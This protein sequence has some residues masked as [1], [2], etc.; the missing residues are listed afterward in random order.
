MGSIMAYGYG[1]GHGLELWLRAIAL[2][3][4]YGLGKWVQLRALGIA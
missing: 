2:A 1:Y 3:E 4:V